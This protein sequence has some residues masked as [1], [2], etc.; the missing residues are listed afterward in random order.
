MFLKVWWIFLYMYSCSGAQV[1]IGPH[2]HG[3]M[4]FVEVRGQHGLAWGVV[5]SFIRLSVQWAPKICQSLL[6]WFLDCRCT[7]TCLHFCIATRDQSQVFKLACQALYQP[8]R[9]P[10][11]LMLYFGKMFCL[12][13]LEKVSQHTALVKQY[14][15]YIIMYNIY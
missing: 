7:A 13:T 1:Y 2:V 4:F 10:S 3:G 12:S 8:S 15:K 5:T 11:H 6:L 9:L 14:F